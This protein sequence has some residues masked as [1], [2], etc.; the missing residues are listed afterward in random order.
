MSF[1]C[2]AQK[3]ILRVVF[4]DELEKHVSGDDNTT[5]IKVCLIYYRV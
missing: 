1:S 4:K 2:D 3:I 5:R